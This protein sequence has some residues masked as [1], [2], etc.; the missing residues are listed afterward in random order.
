MHLLRKKSKNQKIKQEKQKRKKEKQ[1]RK[2]EKKGERKR[3]FS[4][5]WGIPSFY[6]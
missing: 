5:N 6:S 4:F 2:Q 3:D 1:E